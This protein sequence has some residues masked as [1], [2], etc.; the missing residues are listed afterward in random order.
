MTLRSFAFLPT[1]HTN[2]L[3]SQNFQIIKNEHY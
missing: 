3:N 2:K 1:D